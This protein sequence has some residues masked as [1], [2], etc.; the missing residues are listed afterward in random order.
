[1]RT[2]L[3]YEQEL[4]LDTGSTLVLQIKEKEVIPFKIE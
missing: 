3:N 4:F 2:L 1:M